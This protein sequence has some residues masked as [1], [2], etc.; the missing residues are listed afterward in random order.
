MTSNTK[1]AESVQVAPYLTHVVS[2]HGRITLIP[3]ENAGRTRKT[4]KLQGKK[5]KK[6]SRKPRERSVRSEDSEEARFNLGTPRSARSLAS[7]TS[8]RRRP[9]RNTDENRSRGR[10]ADGY[11]EGEFVPCRQ[12]WSDA[13]RLRHKYSG[14]STAY[15][16]RGNFGLCTIFHPDVA[17]TA[18]NSSRRR[19]FKHCTIIANSVA[20]H[21]PI[22][23]GITTAISAAIVHNSGTL[24]FTSTISST[25]NVIAAV[26]V[27]IDISTNLFKPS[28]QVHLPFATNSAKSGVRFGF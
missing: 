15:I 19:Q 13:D 1:A 24:D 28:F 17:N 10:E 16:P 6:S 9:P 14:L 4:S 22:P 25:L 12:H 20:N 11:G 8:T 5:E 7:A 3:P 23:D 27:L 26:T 2:H 18:G 21:R